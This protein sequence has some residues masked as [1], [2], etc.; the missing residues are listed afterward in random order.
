MFVAVL[1]LPKGNAGLGF[2]VDCNECGEVGET[3]VGVMP[4]TKIAIW[5][6]ASLLIK[7]RKYYQ[8]IHEFCDWKIV[9][10]LDEAN[11]VLLVGLQDEL[12]DR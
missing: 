4:D 9:A 6:F 10:I 2:G 1:A 5:S 3:V 12:L 7:K 8:I 11:P